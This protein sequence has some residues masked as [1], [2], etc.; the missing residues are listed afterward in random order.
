MTI[1]GLDHSG[2][3]LCLPWIDQ[4]PLPPDDLAPLI[5]QGLIKLDGTDQGIVLWAP[6]LNRHAEWLTVCTHDRRPFTRQYLTHWLKTQQLNSMHW[7]LPD[8]Q[9]T[10]PPWQWLL[11]QA[12]Y[13][14]TAQAQLQLDLLNPVNR[15]ICQQKLSTAYAF[16][17]DYTY[18]QFDNLPPDHAFWQD[19][20]Q[21]LQ[22]AYSHSVDMDWHPLIRT[23]PLAVLQQQALHVP[24]HTVTAAF[25]GAELAGV[26]VCYYPAIDQAQIGFWAIKPAFKGLG[27]PLLAQTLRQLPLNINRVQAYTHTRLNKVLKAYQTYGFSL[28]SWQPVAWLLNGD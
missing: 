25:S 19:V 21:V 18:R 10:A 5:Q 12:G 15:Q 14:L 1:I 22:V 27:Q 9:T 17:N 3:A 6:G 28:S 23:Q 24:Q 7:A 2:L 11:P 8:E 13:N 20:A 26:C 16:A 4:L